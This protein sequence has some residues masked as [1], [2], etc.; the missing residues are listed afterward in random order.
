MRA[1]LGGCELP[2][3][4]LQHVR[5]CPRTR[6]YKRREHVIA[7]DAINDSVPVRV[8][9]VAAAPHVREL[10]GARVRHEVVGLRGENHRATSCVNRVGE[11]GVAR[12][13]DEA[14][15]AAEV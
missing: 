14:V 10:R 1:L 12:L 15:L 3:I 11:G 9:I 7:V 2:V 13:V 5:I 8:N 6:A 4:N